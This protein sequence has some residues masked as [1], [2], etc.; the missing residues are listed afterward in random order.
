[1]NT[2]LQKLARGAIR[3]HLNDY[4]IEDILMALADEI[5]DFADP[6]KGTVLED[7]SVVACGSIAEELGRLAVHA[8]L[9]EPD[10]ADLTGVNE[11]ADVIAAD[12]I[13]ASAMHA[14]EDAKVKLLETITDRLGLIAARLDEIND[15]LAISL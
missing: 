11:L 8:S 7:D 14:I 15:T 6:A 3:Q 1:M 9:V 4:A 10:Q 5:R 12:E 2:N 13:E